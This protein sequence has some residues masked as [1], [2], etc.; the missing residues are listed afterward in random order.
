MNPLAHWAGATNRTWNTHRTIILRASVALLS[1][2]AALKLGTEFWRLLFDMSP[3]GAIDL[4]ILNHQTRGWFEGTL[5]YTGSTL[6]PHP[7][8]T[9]V[10]LYPFLGWLE[11][12]QARW[13]WAATTVV[14]LGALTVVLVRAS[15][16]TTRLERGLVAV[17][18]LSMNATGVAVG[19]GQVILHVLPVLLTGVLVIRAAPNVRSHLLGSSLIVLALVKPSIAAPFLWPALFGPSRVRLAPLL[20]IGVGY[21]GLTLFASSYQPVGLMGVLSTL[22]SRGSAFT[23]D[24]S[25]A[26]VTAALTDLGL[27]QWS[28]PASALVFTAL[29]VWVYFNRRADGWILLGVSALVVRLG[30]Y[31]L[32][33]DDVLIVVPML[34]LFRVATREADDHRSL[35]AGGL[36]AI[37]IVSMLFLASW[38]FARPPL[39]WLFV[40]GHPLIWIVDLVVLMWIAGHQHRSAGASGRRAAD[41]VG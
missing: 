14:M 6:A 30:I 5:V 2:Y 31:H 9:F 12:A 13:V 20:F 8:A 18:L 29:G 28:L 27:I 11:F 7:P 22:G 17:M 41:G 10:I 16:A 1:L 4:R 19:N 25:Y 24:W 38:Q 34:A 23:G 40:W 3:T 37:S 26:N 15:G 35:L 39:Q 33:Y 36:L 21:L 32:V